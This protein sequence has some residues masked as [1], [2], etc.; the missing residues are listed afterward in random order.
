MDS[1]DG[2]VARLEQIPSCEGEVLDHMIDAVCTVTPLAGGWISGNP[3]LMSRRVLA[4]HTTFFLSHVHH[5][6]SGGPLIQGIGGF[7]VDAAELLGG[8]LAI[9]WYFR[10]SENS[11]FGQCYLTFVIKLEDFFAVLGILYFGGLSAQVFIKKS[12]ELNKPYWEMINEDLILWCTF[13]GLGWYWS[14]S[15]TDGLKTL[16]WQF[17]CLLFTM[18]LFFYRTLYQKLASV[19]KNLLFAQKHKQMFIIV[20]WVNRIIVFSTILTI[21]DISKSLRDMIFMFQGI[22][23]CVAALGTLAHTH[24]LGPTLPK[25]RPPPKTQ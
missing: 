24:K 13:A 7:G 16:S 9:I 12:M 2:I 21:F 19:P 23:A 5:R 3:A 8:I 22:L 4:A 14:P 25:E 18:S 15:H 11:L 20:G 1:M 10:P 17:V 6:F